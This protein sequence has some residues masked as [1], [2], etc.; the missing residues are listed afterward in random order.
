MSRALRLVAFVVA[1]L[2]LAGA[3][4]A[5]LVRTG[6]LGGYGWV[7]RERYAVYRALAEARLRGDRVMRDVAYVEREGWTGRLDLF[8]PSHADTLAPVVVY[9]HS[10][11]WY[12][13]SRQLASLV[14]TQYRRNGFAVANVSYR[15]SGEARAPAAV[16][17]ARCAVRWLATHGAELGIDTSRIVT[18]GASAGGH[19]A[20]MA[21][22]LDARDGFDEGCAQGSVRPVAAI[23]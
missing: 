16:G 21:A 5:V 3:A 2:F 11:G 13:G 8:L 18:A 1:V 22:L 19:L 4:G 20:L 17:D 9:F 14:A 12:S 7:I 10:G 6:A 23:N 15:R